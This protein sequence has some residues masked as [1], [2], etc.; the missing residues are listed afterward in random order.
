MDK[1]QNIQDELEYNDGLGDLLRERE[2]LEFSWTKT[3][4]VLFV[5]LAIVLLGITYLFNAGKHYIASQN[6]S[7]TQIKPS[8]QK[9]SVI[10]PAPSIE[11]S[12]V[13][14]AEAAPQSEKKISKKTLP[15]SVKSISQKKISSHNYKLIAGSFKNKN[16][17]TELVKTL[18]KQ[19][20]D[21]Y[22][23]YI[24]AIDNTVVYRVQAGAFK[25]RSS[26]ANAQAS[27]KKSG[28]ESYILIEK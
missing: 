4:L 25:S 8:A 9:A 23:K 20:I 6:I 15:S 10:E 19:N 11:L 2:K 26:A 5:F 18:K 28:F 24:K 21:S 17:A 27:L 13:N 14:V 12:E 22:V 1:E 7:E 16:N 3:S